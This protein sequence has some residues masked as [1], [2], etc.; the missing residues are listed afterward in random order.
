MDNG[1]AIVWR[2]RRVGMA[3]FGSALTLG[4]RKQGRPPERGGGHS[5][6]LRR[7]PLAAGN[8][9]VRRAA[10][11]NQIHVTTAGGGA[12]PRRPAPVFSQPTSLPPLPLPP[13]PF[14]PLRGNPA[15]TP[16]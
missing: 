3:G 6:A 16:G 5:M 2:R 8:T 15:T 12:R 10:L 1:A 9:Q 4:E 14:H 13:P 11:P 7:S